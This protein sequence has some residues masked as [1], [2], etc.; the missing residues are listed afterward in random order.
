MFLMVHFWWRCFW[1]G[2]LYLCCSETV[3]KGLHLSF[4]KLYCTFKY[5]IQPNSI[6]YSH[7][8]A[9]IISQ[10]TN[11]NT[12]FRVDTPTKLTWKLWGWARSTFPFVQQKLVSRNESQPL[13][14]MER[15][16]KRITRISQV[17]GIAKWHYICYND[18]F[19]WNIWASGCVVRVSWKCQCLKQGWLN[20]V[21]RMCIYPGTVYI[22]IVV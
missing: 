15:N 13:T 9:F 2:L 11:L 8:W 21:C 12:D 5:S 3:Q 18:T 20:N 14:G 1:F 10:A 6:L 16:G 19:Q 22:S 7:L 17:L 4:H